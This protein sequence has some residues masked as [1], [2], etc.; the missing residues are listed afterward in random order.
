MWFAHFAAGGEI[1]SLH[2]VA[3]Y[4][5]K[6]EEIS[7]FIKRS[8]LATHR[9]LVT[10]FKSNKSLRLQKVV[11]AKYILTRSCLIKWQC[12]FRITFNTS[13]FF[14]LDLH[15]DLIDNRQSIDYSCSK[16]KNN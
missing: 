10:E 16:M 3:E 14:A 6:K 15:R 11:K 12:E 5:K 2:K 1:F 4:L 7:E 13:F 9:S 8:D